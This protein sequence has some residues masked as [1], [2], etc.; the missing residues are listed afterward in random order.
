MVPRKYDFVIVGTGAGGATLA[1]E[2]SKRGK[3]V[4]AIDRGKPEKAI[5]TFKDSLRYFDLSYFTKMPPRSKDGA[6]LWRT[7]M[8]GGST[9]VSCGN[10]IRCL[11]SELAEYGIL[12]EQEFEE[13]EREMQ[14][15][16]YNPRRLSQGSKK[17]LEVS[18]ELG[19]T[20]DPMPKFIDPTKC[21]RCGDCAMGCKYDA[22]WTALNYLSE[23]QEYGAEVMCETRVN[24]VLRNNGR[25]TGVRVSGPGGTREIH[26]G[27]V[28][29]CAGGIG[30]PVILQK[31]GFDKAGKSLFMDLLV[32][33]YGET[34]DLSQVEE[35]TMAIV[36]HGA[37][38]SKGFILS[39]FINQ[40]RLLRFIE[41]GIKGI[42]PAKNNLL[43]IM[44]KI[45]DESTGHVNINETFS[46]PITENDR[47]KLREGSLISKEIL[48][49][50]GADRKSIVFS[51]VQGGHPGGTAAIGKIVDKDLQTEVDNLF[52]CD[53]SV[54]P[55]SP[56][57]PPI[58]TI[59]ALAKRLAKILS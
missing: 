30:T 6:V 9:V 10:G 15:V 29:L 34:Q 19:Y 48:I 54:L 23:S 37:Y 1:M 21:R 38:E 17:I 47:K 28:I 31:S 24:K 56:G 45:R 57:M 5:G 3:K 32:N 12:L 35:P 58:L 33:T 44:T 25:A 11:E 36:Y 55:I 53:G 18:R 20:M 26:A 16:D 40:H 46:K 39:P 42:F 7:L 49:E 50:A 41:M 43:G 51:K 27:V 59:V 14:I 52:V 4:L 22:K 13:A 2:L 8:A